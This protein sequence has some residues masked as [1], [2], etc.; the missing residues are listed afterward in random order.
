M[1]ARP[2]TVGELLR[3][4]R[5]D[6]G[7]SIRALARGSGVSKSTLSEWEA[8]GRSPSIYELDRVLGALEAPSLV[9]LRAYALVQAPRG[10]ARIDEVLF[11]GPANPS[12]LSGALLRAI[13]RRTERTQEQVAQAVGVTQAAVA[14]WESGL[15]RPD[16]Q[17][18]RDLCQALGASEAESA[19]LV[20]GLPYLERLENLLFPHIPDTES[21]IANTLFTI[22]PDPAFVL[23]DLQFA[24]IGARLWVDVGRTDRARVLMANCFACY[25]DHLLRTGDDALAF[26]FIDRAY[27]MTDGGSKET[28]SRIYLFKAEMLA[29]N[30]DEGRVKAIKLLQSYGKECGDPGVVDWIRSTVARL[31][32]DLGD[33]E[34]AIDLA[35]EAYFRE[36]DRNGC[37]ARFRLRELARLLIRARRVDEA[38]DL[39]RRSWMPT[40]DWP[41]Y[42]V[43]D[44]ILHAEIRHVL[45]DTEG[46]RAFLDEARKLAVGK[47]Y[48]YLLPLIDRA[49]RRLAA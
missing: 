28:D 5:D 18:M 41:N 21:R 12:V 40:V 14:Q 23:K 45:G 35:M 22:V 47:S 20:G 13:R 15:R 19:A 37:E 9:R 44:D 29:G 39:L 32:F 34:G 17:Q 6:R 26:R 46:V 1:V 48:R 25:A 38:I 33:P 8:H 4:L 36:C 16:G 42:T 7:L 10:E 24:V 11:E 30:G 31:M 3:G 27:Q 49:E 43:E 2:F